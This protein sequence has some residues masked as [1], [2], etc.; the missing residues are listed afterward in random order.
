MSK[1]CSMIGDVRQIE[2]AVYKSVIDFGNNLD[3]VGLV[4]GDVVENTRPLRDRISALEEENGRL[5]ADLDARRSVTTDGGAKPE[6]NNDFE[7]LR[8]ILR[9]EVLIS[10][11]ATTEGVAGT[12]VLGSIFIHSK[13]LFVKGWIIG[14]SPI[15]VSRW[16]EDEI[17]PA[18][19][20]HRLVARENLASGSRRYSATEKG[21][22]FLAWH[23]T[24][25]LKSAKQT[26]KP[27]RLAAK[28]ATPS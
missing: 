16:F 7:T 19:M 22:D 21:L 6:N 23:D 24:F 27:K 26:P 2:G 15:V 18:L 13:N 3:L 25:K 4:P 14:N 11:E 28:D 8:E 17:I 10:A 12:R 9:M 5:Q 1:M 20:I